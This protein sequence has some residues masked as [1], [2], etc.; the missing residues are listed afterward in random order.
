MGARCRSRVV[1]C[2]SRRCNRS[3]GVGGV[4]CAA[5]RRRVLQGALPGKVGLPGVVAAY[6]WSLS[7]WVDTHR[8]WLGGPKGAALSPHQRAAVMGPV[9]RVRG[10]VSSHIGRSAALVL[11]GSPSRSGAL[12]LPVTGCS[13][14]GMRVPCWVARGGL[15]GATSRVRGGALTILSSGGLGPLGGSPNV[16]RGGCG[17]H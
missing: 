13:G 10:G 14:Q 9:P 16:A 1:Q 17:G 4:C 8:R 12:P 15:D 11:G 2:H 5:V 7:C 3:T 6:R